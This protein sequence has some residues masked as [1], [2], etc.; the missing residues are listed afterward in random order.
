MFQKGQCYDFWLKVLAKDLESTTT[1]SYTVWPKS[2][3]TTNHS[4]VCPI[5]AFCYSVIIRT[6]VVVV[7]VCNWGVNQTEV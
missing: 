7:V 1:F 5:V 2:M 6:I 4:Y 3:Y